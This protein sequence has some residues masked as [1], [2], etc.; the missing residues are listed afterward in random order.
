MLCFYF[1]TKLVPEVL[2]L[3]VKSYKA[4]DFSPLEY[5]KCNETREPLSTCTVCLLLFMFFYHIK[6]LQEN[7]HIY[8]YNYPVHV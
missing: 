2:L 7:L 6:I 1:T 5:Y 8:K 3:L 4:E